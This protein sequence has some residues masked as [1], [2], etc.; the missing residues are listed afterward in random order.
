MTLRSRPNSFVSHDDDLTTQLRYALQINPAPLTVSVPGQDPVL[1]SL[2]FVITN[3]T[4]AALSVQSVEVT[5]QVGAGASL[6]STTEGITVAVSDNTNWTVQPPSPVTNGPATFTLEP[7]TGSAVS[8]ASGA[9]VVVQLFQIQTN[10][11]PGNSTIDVDEVV[12]SSPASTSFLVTTFP[13][14]FY[15]NGLAANVQ[16]GSGL[17][18]VAQVIT[19]ATV[20]LLW[21]SSVVDIDAFTIYYSDASRGQQTVTS[22]QTVNPITLGMW[23]SSQLTSDTIFTV[24]VTVDVEG[25]Q[26][27]TASMTTMVSVQNPTLVATAVT[28]GQATVSGPLTANAINGTG[29]TVS[30]AASVGSLVTGGS[31]NAGQ[32]TL[33]TANVSGA[34]NV[35]GP[36]TLA[37]VSAQSVS[38]ASLNATGNVAVSG[39]LTANNVQIQ[40]SQLFGF[41]VADSFS[42][43]NHSIGWYS[44]GWFIDSWNGNG[45]TCWLSGFGG[46]KFFTGS[47]MPAFTIDNGA[48]CVYY[49]SM[50]QASSLALKENIR[51]L[52]AG[53]ASDILKNLDPVRY[54]RKAARDQRAQL[55]FIAEHVPSSVAS[56]DGKAIVPDE[57][58]A[59]LTRV[60]KDQQQM[61]Q[62]LEQKVMALEKWYQNDEG[63]G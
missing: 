39:G 37:A 6:T 19:G 14:G 7:V 12:A 1:A 32:S 29:L 50:Q 28:T 21:N 44:M 24:V 9:S 61:I 45:A 16:S 47:A 33:A 5:I 26:P 43:Q 4:N 15:F 57:I 36:S 8:L 59:V 31:I 13:T 18:P 3:P 30:G 2:E 35:G 60:V 41:N 53:E 22:Q 23:T 54:N 49:G 48:N 38:V 20:T 42:Y 55:G 62:N 56:A 51:A 17:V 46:I 25:G 52:T 58:V 34:L 10:A 40:L 63:V 27:L 11:T